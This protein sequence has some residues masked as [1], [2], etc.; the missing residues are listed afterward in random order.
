MARLVVEGPVRALK[1]ARRSLTGRVALGNGGTAGYES[2]L[3]RDWLMALDFDWRVQRIQ[4]QPYTLTYLLDGKRRR[5]TPDVLAVFEEGGVQRTVVYEVKAHEDLREN[6]A[7]Q[8]P[9]YKAAVA[10][11]RTRGWRFRI[12]T[13]RDIRTPYVNNIKFLRRYRDLK[14]QQL[15]GTALLY[16][17]RALGET[18]PQALLAATWSDNE[19]RLTALPELWRLVAK[20]DIAAALH[21]PLTM[22]TPIW[23][24]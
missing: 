14:E 20:R 16:T 21:D 4:E 5:Y 17:L 1:P 6:W 19:R 3:E 18:T 9:R 22:A 10:D 11:C 2:S 7:E 15:H 24:P 23:L 12:V 13:E 8:R